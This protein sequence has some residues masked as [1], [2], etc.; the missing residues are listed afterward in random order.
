M[1]AVTVSSRVRAR[2]RRVSVRASVTISLQYRAKTLAGKT[3][4]EMTHFFASNGT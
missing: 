2:V 3:V 1:D 4:S